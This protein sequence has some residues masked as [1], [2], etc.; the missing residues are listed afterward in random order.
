LQSIYPE[1]HWPSELPYS[2]KSSRRAPVRDAKPLGYWK[3][4]KNQRTFFD[5]LATKLEVTTPEDWLAVP[6]KVLLEEGGRFVY[7]QYNGS[8]LQGKSPT[9]IYI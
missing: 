1:Q 5:Q 8:L 6:K 7:T 9:K 2:T 3:D 4:V